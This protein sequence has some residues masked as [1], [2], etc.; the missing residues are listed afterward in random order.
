MGD[1]RAIFCLANY[2]HMP[3]HVWSKRNC[4]ICFWAGDDFINN[5]TLQL[6]YHNDMVITQLQSDVD[7]INN[8]C[9]HTSP[10]D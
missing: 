6:F 5:N 2:L 3:I 7:T 1:N 4:V 9:F 8:Q 10:N